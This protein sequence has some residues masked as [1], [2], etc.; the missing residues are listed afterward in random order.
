M[1]PF[2]MIGSF[3]RSWVYYLLPVLYSFRPHPNFVVFTI[4]AP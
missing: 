4:D 1:S 3:A 2:S